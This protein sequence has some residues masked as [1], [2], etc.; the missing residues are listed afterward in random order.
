MG[1]E[2]NSLRKGEEMPKKDEVIYHLA[3]RIN[4]GPQQ[5]IYALKKICEKKKKKLLEEHGEKIKFSRLE[6]A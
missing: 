4:R 5:H 2:P 1:C 6:R 3:Y